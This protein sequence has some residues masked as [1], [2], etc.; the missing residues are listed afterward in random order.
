MHGDHHDVFITLMVV[1]A[2]SAASL[3]NSLVSVITLF[4]ASLLIVILGLISPIHTYFVCD[5][6]MLSNSQ[7]LYKNEAPFCKDTCSINFVRVL[8]FLIGHLI[9]AQSFKDE[10]NPSQVVLI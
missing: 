10:E 7:L 9:I 1:I 8:L 2:G 5:V 3:L 4:I 6:K